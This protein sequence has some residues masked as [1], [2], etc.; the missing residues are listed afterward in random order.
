MVHD[1]GQVGANQIRI[2]TA[3]AVAQ[4]V[5][6]LLGSSDVEHLAYTLETIADQVLEAALETATSQGLTLQPIMQSK[7]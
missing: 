1:S 2:L 7:R 4:E 5:Q 6:H 3:Q